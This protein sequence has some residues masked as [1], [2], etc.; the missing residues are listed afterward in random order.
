MEYS[1]FSELAEQT[2][3]QLEP[4]IGE[5]SA[6]GISSALAG[7]E[8]GIAVEE[9]VYTVVNESVPV[10]AAELDSLR[11]LAAY[12]KDGAELLAKLEQVEPS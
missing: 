7:G 9:M 10:S 5:S 2:A 6:F 4:R 11:K 1:E 12:L 8:T 3:Q